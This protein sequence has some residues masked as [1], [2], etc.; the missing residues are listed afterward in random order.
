MIDVETLARELHESMREAVA[1]G[2]VVNDVGKPFQGWNEISE[3]A[4]EGRRV[5]ARYVLSRFDVS[6]RGAIYGA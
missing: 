1:R 2:L 3:A 4:R 5:Q 6:A